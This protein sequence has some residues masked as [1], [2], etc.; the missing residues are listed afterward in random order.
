LTSAPR[1]SKEHGVSLLFLFQQLPVEGPV[2]LW[3][4][5]MLIA[6]GFLGIIVYLVSR[7]GPGGPWIRR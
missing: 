7:I 5:W 6:A 4:L 2:P 1:G 3:W